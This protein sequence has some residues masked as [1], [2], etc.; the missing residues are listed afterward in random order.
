M[1]KELCLAL[2][3]LCIPINERKCRVG[4]IRIF[5][6]QEPDYVYALYTVCVGVQT[7]EKSYA[8]LHGDFGGQKLV[9]VICRSKT[10]F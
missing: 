7:T 10:L 2:Q 5:V 9:P 4:H 1:I 6:E 8:L 3:V